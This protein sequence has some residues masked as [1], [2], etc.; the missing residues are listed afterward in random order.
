MI[1]HPVC[2]ARWVWH[3][4]RYGMWVEGHDFREIEE[5]LPANVQVLRCTV[6]G[7]ISVSWDWI[8]I[9]RGERG[10]RVQEVRVP[11]DG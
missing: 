9:P 5:P 4:L 1:P 8:P 6:C 11:P 7:E 2:F 10:D 3:S